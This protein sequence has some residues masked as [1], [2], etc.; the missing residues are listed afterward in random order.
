MILL[1]S[2]IK[3][4]YFILA[5][6]LIIALFARLY[7]LDNPVADWH[8]WRQADTAAVTRNFVKDGVNLI[9]P[10][11]DDISSIQSGIDNPQGIRMVE[12]PLF[13]AIHATLYIFFPLLGLEVWGRLV[14]VMI[15]LTTSFVLFLFV[16]KHYGKSIG[17]LTC[18]FFLFF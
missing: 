3:S 11:F 2:V 9:Y 6:I 12:F 16:K 5:I 18:F 13:N 10:K 8:S 7:K 4:E 1:K 15:T 17:L 14:S